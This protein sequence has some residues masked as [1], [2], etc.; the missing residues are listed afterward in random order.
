M[1]IFSYDERTRMRQTGRQT[2]R[3]RQT[4]RERGGK[5]II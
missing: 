4:K 5:W 3:L 1:N 2:D